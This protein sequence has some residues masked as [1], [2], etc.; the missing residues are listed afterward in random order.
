MVISPYAEVTVT[1]LAMP[2][3]VY[4][5]LTPPVFVRESPLKWV[6]VLLE[7][8]IPAFTVIPVT[9]SIVRRVPLAGIPL[10]VTAAPTVIVLAASNVSVELELH[11]TGL[12]IV[13]LP[14][15]GPE[16]LD[17]TVEITTLQLANWVV[18]SVFKI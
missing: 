2:M 14:P 18:K 16:P 3:P 13:M 4:V 12:D 6:P 1:P 11:E 5:P 9:A 10:A 7:M 15:F 17:P 8:E